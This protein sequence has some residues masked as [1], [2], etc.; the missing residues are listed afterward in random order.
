MKTY[1]DFLAVGE[2]EK[3]RMEFILAAIKEHESSDM[4][5]YAVAADKYYDCENPTINQYEKIL[6]DI[7]GKAHVDMW[8]AN[9]KIASSFFQFVVD[10]ENGYLLGNGVTFK[11]EDTKDKLGNRKNTFDQQ[12]FEANKQAAI[13]GVSYLFWNLDHIEV[14]SVLEYAPLFDEEN[15]AMV[16][17]IRFWQLDYTKPL[18]VTLFEMDGYTDYVRMHGEDMRVLIPKR[19]YI[20]RTIGSAVDRANGNVIYEFENYPGF[21]IIPL[22][23]NKKMRSELRGKRNTLDALD[24]ATSGMVNNSDEGNLIYWVLNNAGGMDDL[25]DQKFLERLRTLHVVHTEDGVN[26]EPHSIETPVE[27]AQ[28]TIDTLQKRLYQD[29]QAFDA[30]AVSAGN[31][32]ATAIKASYVPLDLK[33]DS[34]EVQ[35]TKAINALLALVGIDDEPSYTRNKLINTQEE[36]QTLLLAAQYLDDEYITKKAVTIMGDPDMADEIMKRKD[37]ESLERFSAVT[38]KTEQEE[39]TEEEVNA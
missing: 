28:T 10:Q 39:E 25:D 37:A 12:I 11:K 34:I 24:L 32:T 7:S 2:D 17:G 4:Y 27:G 33:V 6:Y 21:P 14:F 3:R 31:Q 36:M 29:F 38:T 5:K 20:T 18:R 19:A 26:A 22:K 35:V 1:Q 23:N 9:H 8:T 30:S 13:G 16:A 15:G